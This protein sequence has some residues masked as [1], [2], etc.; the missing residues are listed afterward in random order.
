[1]FETNTRKASWLQ[2]RLYS[3]ILK[4]CRVLP[5]DIEKQTD[6]FVTSPIRGMSLITLF[7][8]FSKSYINQHQM[9]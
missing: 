6:R 7:F 5:K 8:L 3:G 1:M 2:A 9:L 4:Q